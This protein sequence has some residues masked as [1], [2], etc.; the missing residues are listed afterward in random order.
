MS[1]RLWPI[2]W[3]WHASS[4]LSLLCTIFKTIIFQKPAHKIASFAYYRWCY[5]K[6]LH[7]F[8]ISICMINLLCLSFI[9]LFLWLIGETFS[10]FLKFLLLILCNFVFS[11]LFKNLKFTHKFVFLNLGLTFLSKKHVKIYFIFLL[12]LL[13]KS[14]FRPKV[15]YRWYFQLIP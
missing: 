9:H 4:F 13:I 10:H 6:T 7:H 15:I 2:F 14:D 11:S 3:T 8:K 1:L 5:L 12:F